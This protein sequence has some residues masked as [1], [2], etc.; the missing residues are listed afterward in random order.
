MNGMRILCCREYFQNAQHYKLLSILAILVRIGS[1]RYGCFKPVLG[2][3]RKAEVII[4]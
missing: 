4:L 2:H 1:S 3:P